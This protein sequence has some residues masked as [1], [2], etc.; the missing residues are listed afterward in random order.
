[1]RGVCFMPHH[2]AHVLC[3]MKNV[4]GNSNRPDMPSCTC[5]PWQHRNLLM[6]ADP[7]DWL[8]KEDMKIRGKKPKKGK[9]YNPTEYEKL[10]APTLKTDDKGVFSWD[11]KPFETSAGPVKA[12]LPNALVS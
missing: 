3:V 10:I 4:E 11:G 1:M 8:P 9:A 12:D 5:L 7:S 2:R 6:F